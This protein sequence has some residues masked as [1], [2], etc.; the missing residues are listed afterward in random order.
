MFEWIKIIHVISSAILLGA[1]VGTVFYFW[2]AN[3]QSDIQVIIN[4]AK[5]IIFVGVLLTGVSGVIQFITGLL[6]VFFK[7]ISPVSFWIIGSAVGYFVAA[8]CWVFSVYLQMRCRDLACEALAK[9][10]PL[11]D[12]Y[13]RCYKMWCLLSIPAFVALLCVLYWMV[14]HS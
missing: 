1:G 14:N 11:S 9:Q 12:Q 7:D 10:T 4:T 13:Q 3:R 8:I 5:H 6:L 2:F